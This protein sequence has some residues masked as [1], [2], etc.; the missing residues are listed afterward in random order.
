[1]W[2]QLEVFESDNSSRLLD[3]S[4]IELKKKNRKMHRNLSRL[5]HCCDNYNI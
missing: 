5:I 2:G 4:L 3:F 1:M